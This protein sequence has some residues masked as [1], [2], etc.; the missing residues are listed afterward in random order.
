MND[1]AL[2]MHPD[3]SA[4]S[5][6]SFEHQANVSFVLRL[7]RPK[8]LGP[9]AKSVIS[10]R[11]LVT[12]SVRFCILGVVLLAKSLASHAVKLQ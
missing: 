3:S 6:Y 12:L 8:G 1:N 2:G 11:L 7:L 4:Y 5:L 10:P 9:I